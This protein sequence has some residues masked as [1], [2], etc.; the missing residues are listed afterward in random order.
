MLSVRFSDKIK[1]L[2]DAPL[3]ASG[4]DMLQVNVGYRCNLACK[5]CHVQ[6][7][8]DRQEAISRETV[9]AV[10]DVV[11]DGRIKT[12]DITGGA[13][14]LNSHFR[15]LIEEAESA[16]CHVVVR[17]NL[18]IFYEK[19]MED[20]FDFY[21][22]KHIELV[23]SLPSCNG[24]HVDRVRGKGVFGKSIAAIRKLNSLGYG[25]DSGRT[26]NLVYNPAGAFLPPVQSSLEVAYKK[27]LGSAFGIIFNRLYTFANMPV[28][29][30]RQFLFRSG[31]FE[32]YMEKLMQAFNP[33]TLCGLMCRRMVS[34]AWDGRLY[35]CDFNQMTGLGIAEGYPVVITDFDHDRLAARKISVDDHCYGCTAGQGST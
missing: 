31:N 25:G 17:T 8:A 1:A 28:G 4:I 21:D 24:E 7:G 26:L 27:E 11:R 5:H 2:Q 13:P 14:E 29:R 34:V 3:T 22:G 20:L 35:D 19:G 32:T 10:L 18:S 23:A 16:G 12:V 33:E 9:D 30:F 6:G 15:Y